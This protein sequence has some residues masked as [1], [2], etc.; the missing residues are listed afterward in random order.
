M[1]GSWDLCTIVLA[2]TTLL[3]ILPAVF[4]TYTNI[5]DVLDVQRLSCT[6]TEKES[7]SAASSGLF[8]LTKQ[9]TYNSACFIATT[10]S[11]FAHGCTLYS[12]PTSSFLCL[13]SADLDARLLLQLQF[14][15]PWAILCWQHPCPC[16]WVLL[17]VWID[18]LR[19][20][21]L[22]V[23]ARHT[24]LEQMHL[25][26]PRAMFSLHSYWTVQLRANPHTSPNLPI[27]AILLAAWSAGQ[28]QRAQHLSIDNK[29][30]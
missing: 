5:W 1:P 14:R 20:V 26:V 30:W 23:S 21:P 3:H 8:R 15:S 19:A 17:S 25:Q 13:P 11:S 28:T 29:L 4:V 12:R 27:P 2:H 24:L 16:L 10:S 6:E 9:S 22:V 7:P 18:H